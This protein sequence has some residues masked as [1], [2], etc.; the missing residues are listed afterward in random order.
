[1]REVGEPRLN[2]SICFFCNTSNMDIF[3]RM[4]SYMTD[5]R[6]ADRMGDGGQLRNAS[7]AQKTLKRSIHPIEKI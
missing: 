1:M 3:L 5:N 6:Q 4:I 7:T 2:Q